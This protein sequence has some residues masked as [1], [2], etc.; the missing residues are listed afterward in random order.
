MAL[1]RG[2][3][4][5]AQAIADEIRS[6]LNLRPMDPLDPWQLATHLDIPIL[7]LSDFRREVPQA[8]HHLSHI[9]PECFSAVTV[10]CGI[11]RTIVHNDSHAR[12][13]QVSNITHELAHGLLLHPPTPALNNCGCRNWNQDIEDEANFLSP[14]L[15]ISDRAAVHIALNNLPIELAAEQY[16]VSVQLVRYRLNI[17]GAYMR[18][19]R[20]RARHV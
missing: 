20:I 11:A 10:F 12:C 1:R 15:L 14:L 7:G 6:E 16:G 13:R 4:S 5:E 8:V 3:K 17:A 2:F 18:S 9:E 19:A